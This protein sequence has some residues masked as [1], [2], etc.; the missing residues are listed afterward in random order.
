[1]SH[2]Q[3]VYHELARIRAATQVSA[4]FQAIQTGVMAEMNGALDS[5]HGE[6]A[7]VRLLHEESMAAQQAMVQREALQ[8]RLEEFIYQTEKLVNEFKSRKSDVPM[9]SR[10]FTLLGILEQIK[11]ENIS[12]SMI[13][14]RD[15][16]AAFDRV[17]SDIR[18]VAKALK[19]EP[20]VQEA[21]AWAK[22]EQRKKNEE[23]RR[24]EAVRQQGLQRELERLNTELHHAQQ[25]PVLP[26][27][28]P[29][30]WAIDICRNVKSNPVTLILLIAPGVLALIW[31]L[32][33]HQNPPPLSIWL[34][35]LVGAYGSCFLPLYFFIAYPIS[36]ARILAQ[37]QER[38]TQ[39]RL[40]E[41]EISTVA[42]QSPASHSAIPMTQPVPER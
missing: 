5:I 25:K 11:Q 9:S 13:R 42:Q 32:F 35:A 16:K 27:P 4:A 28:M 39:I 7:E 40:I 17:V 20:E 24:L 36:I 18:A 19:S 34:F 41:S 6:M 1:M 12:T 29:W 2:G 38:S 23:R 33:F 8:D 30:T 15:N 31:R 22:E 10:Y 14:G 21:I 3:N 37:N 26:V